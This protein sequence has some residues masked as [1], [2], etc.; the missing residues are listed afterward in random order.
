MDS[1]NEVSVPLDARDCSEASSDMIPGQLH[2]GASAQSDEVGNETVD[3]K[4][5]VI[6]EPWVSVGVS[7][8][9]VAMVG[10]GKQG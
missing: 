9:I 2:A 3:I 5:T 6:M 7:I 1:A 10:W 8:S 4:L